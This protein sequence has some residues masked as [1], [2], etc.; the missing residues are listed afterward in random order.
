MSLVSAQYPCRALKTS[1]F[2]L[3]PSQIAAD[4]TANI[5]CRSLFNGDVHIGHTVAGAGLLL[6]DMLPIYISAT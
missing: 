6:N 2:F 1:W 5:N 4:V 3:S